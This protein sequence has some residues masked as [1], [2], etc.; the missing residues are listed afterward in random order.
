MR[1]SERSDMPKN[2]RFALFGMFGQGN[3]G[4]DCTLDALKEGIHQR[5]PGASVYCIC[6][7]PDVVSTQVGIPAV[8]LSAS[9]HSHRRPSLFVRLGGVVS[10]F[11]QA[12]RTL[13][14]T[15]ALF[16]AGTGIFEDNT[17]WSRKWL[18]DIITWFLA[19]RIRGC[20]LACVS[21]GLGP[22]HSRL[23][24]AIIGFALQLCHYVSYRDE[25]SLQYAASLALGSAR[26]HHVFPDLAFSLAR[27]PQEQSG[28][29]SGGRQRIGVGV[30]DY[31]GQ[32]KGTVGN[33]DCYRAY[34][35]RTAEL[36]HWLVRN[37]YDVRIIYGDVRHDP[38][39]IADLRHRLELAGIEIGPPGNVTV[40]SL[41][42]SSD[43]LHE[44]GSMTI[45]VAPRYHNLLL[46]L[47]SG[48]PAISLSYHE[49]NDALLAR[50]GLREFAHNIDELDQVK[51]TTQLTQLRKE[52]ELRS[53]LVRAG[54]ERCRNELDEQ[55]ALLLQPYTSAAE[56]SGLQVTK[57]SHDLFQN[58]T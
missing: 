19:A 8:A 58:R 12:W 28:I 50:C 26:K 38:R 5:L 32:R 39:V 13:R 20:R 18:L 33:M 27:E 55:Y 1:E 29:R 44:L 21:I 57:R 10:R 40:A 16:V 34:L 53:E 52:I 14:G 15:S 54:V 25:T 2:P 43:L 49:K 51:L 11:V 6:P 22:I 46:A 41:C 24:R 30:M 7:A 48:K 36:V 35:D 45:V 23:A 4:N 9:S 56:R 3:L 37:G 42:S 17:G 47:V 31:F